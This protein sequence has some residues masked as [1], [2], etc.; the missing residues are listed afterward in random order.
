MILCMFTLFWLVQVGEIRRVLQQ[1]MRLN[2]KE[3][4]DAKGTLDGGDVLYTGW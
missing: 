2:V 4:G 3:V 1:D